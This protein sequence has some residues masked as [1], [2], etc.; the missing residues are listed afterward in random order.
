MLYVNDSGEL[1]IRMPD[2]TDKKAQLPD[3]SPVFLDNVTDNPAV[4]AN[5]YR[6]FSKDASGAAN[7]HVR[8]PDGTVIQLTGGGGLLGTGG[9]AFF[10]PVV[11][12]VEEVF[13][14]LT[15][16]S[17]IAW[18]TGLSFDT[19]LSTIDWLMVPV[20][21]EVQVQSPFIGM[22]SHGGMLYLYVF[23]PGVGTPQSRVNAFKPGYFDGVPSQSFY[24]YTYPLGSEPFYN[25]IVNGDEPQVSIDLDGYPIGPFE[26]VRVH[27]TAIMGAA[28][29][30]PNPQVLP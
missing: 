26:T 27:A 25:A 5:K 13:D 24:S 3:G 15:P 1:V 14:A 29:I 18:N 8:A 6:V 7:L 10:D 16:T 21:V 20:W 17:L 2:G 19:S 11:G 4:Q 23:A 9:G 28:M 30:V 22:A 12:Q